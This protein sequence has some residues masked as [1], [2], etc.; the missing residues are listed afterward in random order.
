[1]HNNNTHSS[2]ATTSRAMPIMK[3][4]LDL[5]NNNNNNME[6]LCNK[7]T[8][9][10]SAMVSKKLDIPVVV[11][12]NKKLRF[13]ILRDF[14]TNLREVIFSTK[15]VVLFPAV[16]LAVAADFY[17]FG[18]VSIIQI[19]RSFIYMTSKLTLRIYVN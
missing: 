18:R 2:E 5:E 7:S 1:M 13:Q 3:E 17:S 19:I 15:L 10:G 14:M 8:S 6:E 16:P 4:E 9:S 12:N 11:I